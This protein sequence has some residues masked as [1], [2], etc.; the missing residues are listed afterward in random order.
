MKLKKHAVAI[1]LIALAIVAGSLLSCEQRTGA[2]S[3]K[4]LAPE[5][6]LKDL[7]GDTFKLADTRGK[8]VILNF[9]STGCKPCKDEMPQFEMLYNKYKDK[10]LLFVG[11]SLADPESASSFVAAKGIT[12]PIVTATRKVA[13]DYG[14]IQW[15]P[16]TFVIDREGYISERFVGPKST[17]A[18]EDVIENLL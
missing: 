15:I 2:V 1:S 6:T 5:F 4:S 17:K 8:V 13:S 14:G 7:K 11:M 16:T 3:T 10:G 12:F 9:W 18:W